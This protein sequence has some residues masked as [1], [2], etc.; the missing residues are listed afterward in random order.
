ME[1]IIIFTFKMRTLIIT[2]T[3]SI[4]NNI[5]T[6]WALNYTYAYFMLSITLAEWCN[7][8]FE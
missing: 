2:Y 5:G 6:K 7:V 4:L 8:D 3:K 1:K